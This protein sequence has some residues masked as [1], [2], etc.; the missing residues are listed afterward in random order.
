MTRLLAVL[1]VIATSLA[2]HSL[3]AQA[4]PTQASCDLDPVTMECRVDVPVDRPSTPGKSGDE[5]EDEGG[6]AGS[7]VPL[8]PPPDPGSGV[9]EPDC[10]NW[11]LETGPE[12]TAFLATAEAPAGWSAYLCVEGRRIGQ[13]AA[14]APEDVPARPAAEDVAERLWLRVKTRMNAPTVAADPPVGTASIVTLPVFVQVTN[15]QGAQTDE[16]C[17]VG[18]CVS[19]TAT[20]TLL[21]YPGLPE[22]SPVVCDPPGTRYDPNGAEPEVQAAAPGAC[23]YVYDQRS[24]VEGRPDA[25]PAEVRITWDVSWSGAGQSGEFEPLTLATAVPRQVNE[26]QTVVVDGSTG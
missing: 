23:A 14:F 6:G 4:A 21:F 15:W 8:P 5:P 24:G 12:A 22:A 26:V 19:I 9:G 18:V 10:L 2:L 20:P 13:R 16:A 3:P 17:E 1:A 25:W 11:Q 7:G